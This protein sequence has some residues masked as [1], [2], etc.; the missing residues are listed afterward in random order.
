MKQKQ[1]ADLEIETIKLYTKNEY[2]EILV[3]VSVTTGLSFIDVNNY[4]C[5]NENVI[6]MRINN[7]ARIST[8]NLTNIS[9]YAILSFDENLE[10]KGV[11][12]SIKSS[13]GDYSIS[14]P[15]KT[16]LFLR[17]PHLLELDQ[18]TDLKIT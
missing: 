5:N 6:L 1:S 2:Q 9:P 4:N 15:Y 14:T 18:I 12:F 13:K 3:N 17:L 8:I 11:S 10:F 7:T 16:L